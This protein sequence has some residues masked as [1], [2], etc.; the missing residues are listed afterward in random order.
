VLNEINS[1]AMPL[2]AHLPMLRVKFFM[3]TK[4]GEWPRYKGFLL[5]GALGASLAKLSP[6]AFSTLMGESDESGRRYVMTPPFDEATR[7]IEGSMLTCEMTLLGEATELVLPLALAFMQIGTEGIGKA[8]ARFDLVSIS[9]ITPH[10]ESIFYS[11][12]TGFD[13]VPVAWAASEVFAF[14][15]SSPLPASNDLSLVFRSPVRLK[16]ENRLVRQAPDFSLLWHRLFGR[17][18]LLA[19]SCGAPALPPDLRREFDE[20]A[21]SVSTRSH[22]LSWAEWPRYSSRQGAEMLFGGLLGEMHF[23]GPLT[24]FVPWM[25]LAEYLHLGGKTTFGLGALHLKMAN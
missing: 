12:H 16:A 5:H 19:K 2:L 25:K 20:L 3:C 6:A 18:V 8:K 15:G 17:V 13:T 23:H 10:V 7:Y 22:C 11:E 24:T 21:S 9:S 1:R 14:P 4:D